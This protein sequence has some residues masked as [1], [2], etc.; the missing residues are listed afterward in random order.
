MGPVGSIL[1]ASP[2]MG[3]ERLMGMWGLGGWC[4]DSGRGGTLVLRPFGVHVEKEH[5]Q[6]GYQTREMQ[7]QDQPPCPWKGLLGRLPD[8]F[9]PEGSNLGGYGA[10]VTALGLATCIRR[11]QPSVINRG[12][13]QGGQ[14]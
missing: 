6:A 7:V 11:N 10:A 8:I 3:P 2:W 14:P 5:I 13:K 4:R 1:K 9:C 12:L